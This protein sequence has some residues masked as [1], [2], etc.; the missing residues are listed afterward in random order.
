MQREMQSSFLLEICIFNSIPANCAILDLISKGHA[1]FQ[2]NTRAKDDTLTSGNCLEFYHRGINR[3][4]DLFYVPT[5][6]FKLES[7]N[8]PSLRQLPSLGFS[9]S[10]SGVVRLPCQQLSTNSAST[11]LI[12]PLLII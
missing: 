3:R 5:S 10:H 1:D 11:L 8:N 2:A 4:V 12:F 6:Y 9:H 7:F